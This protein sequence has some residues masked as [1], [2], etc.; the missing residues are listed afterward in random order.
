M[1]GMALFY[2]HYWNKQWSSTFGYSR[3]DTENSDGQA[4]DAF[5]A[6]QYA[7]VNLMHYPAE[8]VMM[9]AE[10][11]WGRRENNPELRGTDAQKTRLLAVDDYRIQF[12]FKYNFSL[13]IGG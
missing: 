10:F 4:A 8:N 12:S 13:S 2:D 11:Q 1:V 5:K 9:G 6:G 7:L 3:L